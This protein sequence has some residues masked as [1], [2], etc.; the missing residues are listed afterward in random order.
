MQF[1]TP[2]ILSIIALLAAMGSVAW[3]K[4]LS[5]RAFKSTDDK[6][7]AIEGLVADIHKEVAVIDQAIRTNC[8]NII[9]IQ[10]NATTLAQSIDQL[11]TGLNRE[12]QLITQHIDAIHGKITYIDDKLEKIRDRGL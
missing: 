2:Q 4:V 10:G 1:D 9:R 7:K 12:V 5:A 6:I 11:R 8:E 3:N